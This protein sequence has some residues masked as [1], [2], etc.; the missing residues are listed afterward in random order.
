MRLFT[1]DD[2]HE[3]LVSIGDIPQQLLPEACGPARCSFFG[4]FDFHHGDDSI[5]TLGKGPAT[6]NG[7]SFAPDGSLYVSLWYE[8]DEVLRFRPAQGGA[9][10]FRDRDL[11]CDRMSISYVVA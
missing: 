4:C 1:A 3:P 9:G 6:I 7:G 10:R 2:N 5:V 8:T 11:S